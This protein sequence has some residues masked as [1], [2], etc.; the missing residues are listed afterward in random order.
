MWESLGITQFIVDMYELYHIERLENAFE[1]IDR[2]M[3]EAG[4]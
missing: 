2:M 3:A 1:D 4:A